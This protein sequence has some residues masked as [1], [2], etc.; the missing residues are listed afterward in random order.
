MT[1]D[2]SAST[3]PNV[4]SATLQV[5]DVYAH[6]VGNVTALAKGATAPF[7]SVQVGPVMIYVHGSDEYDALLK[8]EELGEGR[9]PGPRSTKRLAW[10]RRSRSWHDHPNPRPRQPPPPHRKPL[11]QR[12]ATHVRHGGRRVPRRRGV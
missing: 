3:R 12:R 5:H 8:I 2:T 10:R 1:M 4:P 6:N 11:P 7:A 9:S